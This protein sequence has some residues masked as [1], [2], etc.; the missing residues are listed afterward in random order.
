MKFPPTGTFPAGR[1]VRRLFAPALTAVL[2]FGAGGT[3]AEPDPWEVSFAGPEVLKTDWSTRALDVADL[4]RDGLNDLVM[5]NNDTARIELFYQLDPDSKAGDERMRLP[6]NR[7]EPVLEDARFE[8]DSITVGFQMFDLGAGDFNADGRIDLAYTARDVPLTIRYQGENGNW[9][10]TTEF[11]RF[12][13][14]GWVST[15]EVADL[16][17]DGDK[18]LVV[19]GGDAL[20]VFHPD[21]SGDPGE[22]DVYRLTGENPFNLMLEDVNGDGRLDA[23]YISTDGKQALTVREQLEGATFGPEIRF[24]LDRPVR[25]V[26]AM[27]VSADGETP[28]FCAVNSRSGGLE[29]FTIAVDEDRPETTGLE[30]ADPEIY[31]VALDGRSSAVYALADVNGDGRRDVLVGQP[32]G[33]ELTLYAAVD[34][35]FAAP[36]DFPTFSGVNA[37][38]V[39]R[40]GAEGESA[41]ALV[42][43]AEKLLGISVS[44][45]NGRLSFPHQIALE[46]GEPLSC[47]AF[48]ADGDGLDEL[49]VAVEDEGTMRL[50]LLRPTDRSDGAPADW[51]VVSEVD[52]EGVRRKPSAIRVID[53]FENGRSGL[54]VFVPREAPVL[55]AADPGAPFDLRARAMDSSVRES[56]LKD[57]EPSQ[58]SCFDVD[59][60][61][62]KELVV[63]RTGFA[64]AL[65]LSGDSLEMVD[66]FNARRSEDAVS[67]VIPLMRDGALERVLLSVEGAGELQFLER[68]DDGVFRFESANEVGGID[69]VDWTFGSNGDGLDSALLLAGADRFWRLLGRGDR[70]VRREIGSYETDLEDVHFNHVAGVDF[71]ED[72]T[73]EL[74]AVDGAEHVVEIVSFEQGAW[75]SRTYWEIFEQN[76]HYQGRTGADV[77][78]REVL[79]EDLN[80]D[81]LPDFAFLVHDR[82]LIYPRE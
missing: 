21:G 18:E 48:D 78:P 58:V 81:G 68:G 40:F 73:L 45:G 53:A 10:E 66:Q 61:G 35:G 71:D 16:D 72:G 34:G 24:V 30:H 6:R 51:T 17:G 65:Q 1:P 36:R 5:I 77:E 49:A 64:R 67:A 39:G 75:R 31:P 63:G 28:A 37:I 22:P 46:A 76:L 60:D 47:Q 15:L 55:L 59:G 25:G 2:V 32:S 7:W 3:S 82:I 38:S 23:L 62:G 8:N 52:L 50:L 42:S 74:I 13:A 26:T 70:W 43:E 9:N 56:M 57:M 69:L 12:E 41:I 44:G 20:R 29:L 14:L 79:A 4:D 11:D 33:A 19:L 80:G 27:P 54:M